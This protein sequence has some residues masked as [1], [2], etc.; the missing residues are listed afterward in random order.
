MSEGGEAKDAGASRVKPRLEERVCER[1]WRLMR[2]GCTSLPGTRRPRRRAR[3]RAIE[4]ADGTIVE[5][6]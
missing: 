4:A 5:R 1:G 6:S 3:P 2:S